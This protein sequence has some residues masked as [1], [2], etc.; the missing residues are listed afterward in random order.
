L[1]TAAGKQ[2]IEKEISMQIKKSFGGKKEEYIVMS[3]PM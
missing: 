2:Q 1:N 3:F